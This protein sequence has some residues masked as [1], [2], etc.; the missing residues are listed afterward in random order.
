MLKEWSRTCT[1]PAPGLPSLDPAPGALPVV[2]GISQVLQ[3]LWKKLPFC[4]FTYT[5]YAQLLLVQPAS[6]KYGGGGEVG[7]FFLAPGA[8]CASYTSA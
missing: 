7:T 2:D 1:F 4:L 6:K 5:P 3:H 8:N